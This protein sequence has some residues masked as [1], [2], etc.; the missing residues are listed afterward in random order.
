MMNSVGLGASEGRDSW[1]NERGVSGGLAKGLSLAV[2]LW[3]SGKRG[4]DHGSSGSRGKQLGLGMT[5]G[6][7]LLEREERKRKR[8]NRKG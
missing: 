7:H 5:S 4:R 2:W 8:E 6:S 1:A 3:G